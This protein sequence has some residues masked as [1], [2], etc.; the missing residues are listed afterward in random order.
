MPHSRLAESQ[1][2]RAATTIGH[3]NFKFFALQMTD[4]H[5]G[6]LHR[7]PWSQIPSVHALQTVVYL[8]FWVAFAVLLWRS[9]QARRP[10]EPFVPWLLACAPIIA[11]VPLNASRAGELF[12][13]MMALGGY[14]FFLLLNRLGTARGQR[15]AWTILALFILVPM[16]RFACEY[17]TVKYARSVASSFYPHMPLALASA[18]R[19]AG[20]NLP[21]YF[22]EKILLNYIDVL[23][24]DK[25][26]PATFQHSGATWDNPNFGR[27]HFNE[28]SLP[29][30]PRPFVYIK[31]DWMEPV[32]P[33]A[34]QL[35]DFS[36][37]QV[38]MCR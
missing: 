23:F 8:L 27:F 34:Q 3:H 35:A 24:S 32:C 29:S 18:E 25:I 11:L 26:D 16:V 15:I 21:I 31:A 38:G 1:A 37:L 20:P 7:L 9:L 30:T 17:Y 22:P 12:L 28:A 14:G 6:F 13:P 36:E 10:L 19:M 4:Y 5:A 2:D 33:Q